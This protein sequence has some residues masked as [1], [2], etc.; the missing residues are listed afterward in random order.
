MR[1]P[2]DYV[3]EGLQSSFSPRQA[4]I[5]PTIMCAPTF[6]SERTGKKADAP[7]KMQPRI[8]NSGLVALRS[9]RPSRP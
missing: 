7:Q 3:L 6:A 5:A 8:S 2:V 1:A 4:N 9:N